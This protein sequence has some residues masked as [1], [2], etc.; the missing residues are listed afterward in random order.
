MVILSPQS[1]DNDGVG[2]KGSGDT[3]RVT[4]HTVLVAFLN[5]SL[6]SDCFNDEAFV[7]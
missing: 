5:M 4:V 3:T 1:E 6:R 2:D 7:W